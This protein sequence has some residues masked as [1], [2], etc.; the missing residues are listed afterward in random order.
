MAATGIDLASCGEQDGVIGTS[1][2]S[3]DAHRWW[4]AHQL[5]TGLGD[6]VS[7]TQLTV[8]VAAPTV[9]VTAATQGHCNK[10]GVTNITLGILATAQRFIY[11]FFYFSV[12]PTVSS[13]DE[14]LQKF[15]FL[16]P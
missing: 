11:L 10:Y 9:H 13:R 15:R 5:W 7:G 1:C 6:Q 16:T 4:E 3:D 14:L 12:Q 2:D 8:T